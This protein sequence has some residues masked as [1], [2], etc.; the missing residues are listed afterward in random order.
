MYNLYLLLFILL[1]IIFEATFKGNYVR[2]TRWFLL[3]NNVSR[4]FNYTIFIF[5]Q[6]YSHWTYENVTLPFVVSVQLMGL[7]NLI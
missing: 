7:S 4:I 2:I 5:F 6:N 3:R 1:R